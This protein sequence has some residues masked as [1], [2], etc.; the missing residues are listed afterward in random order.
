MNFEKFLPKISEIGKESTGERQVE[1]E[2]V[3]E[4][5]EELKGLPLLLKG[6]I[7]DLVLTIVGEKPLTSIGFEI[8]KDK[9]WR[10]EELFQGLKTILGELNLTFQMI[11][12]PGIEK[13]EIAITILVA[14]SNEIISKAIEAWKKG[15]EETIG[16]LYGYPET[17]VKAFVEAMEDFKTKEKELLLPGENWVE[18]VDEETRKEIAQKRLLEFVGFRL[19]RKHYKEE[20]KVAERWRKVVERICPE[21]LE[22]LS[23]E[24]EPWQFE[25]YKKYERKT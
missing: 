17:A 21:F 5:I 22:D 6:N 23:K 3:K 19:S 10:A 2:K 1:K 25:F 15:D 12:R 9:R 14:K 11:E 7:L 18:Y 24:L 13:N 4:A 20:L 8:E 16:K